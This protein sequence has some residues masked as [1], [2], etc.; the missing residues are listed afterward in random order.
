MTYTR[1]VTPT[2]ISSW[3]AHT[4]RNPP[5]QEAGVDYYCPTGTPILAAGNGKVVAIGGTI[6]DPT[7]RYLTIDLDDGRRVRYLHLSRWLKT[8]GNRVAQGAVVAYSGASGYG[9]E[10]F[11]EPSRNAAF[12]ANTGGDHVHTTLWPRWAYSFGINA[13]TLDFEAYVD[14]GQP[15]ATT[16]TE[17]DAMATKQE[18]KDSLFEVLTGVGLGPGGRNHFDSLKFIADM[19]AA[20]ATAAAGARAD[21]NYIHQL[22]PYSLR[23]I[24]EA[25]TK[26]EI[27]LTEAQIA[28]IGGQLSAAAVA[29]IDAAL[30]DDFEGVKARLAE[31]PEETILALKSAL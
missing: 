12:W 3:L 18:I 22:S 4:R 7:G 9:S 28:A 21:L 17:W 6:H 29:G 27:S 11:G 20:S 19:T 25:Q 23:A 14:S 1:P 15:A 30:R 13:G 31:L 26:G 8:A 10:F 24:L 16:G 2:G 5:S